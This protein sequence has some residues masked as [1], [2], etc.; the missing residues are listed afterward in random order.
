[1]NANAVE[2][3][4]A[5]EWNDATVR[6]SRFGEGLPV[7]LCHGTPW[8]SYVWRSTIEA[9]TPDCAVY[10]WDMVGYGQSDKPNSD[11]S[12]GTQG[13]LL[14]ALV[15]HWNLDTPDVIAH[16]YGGTVS[17]RAHLLHGMKVR[18]LALVDV[19]ALTP[20]GSP[21]FRL[22]AEHPDVFTALPPNLHEA[23]VREYI[24]G[25]SGPG[26]QPAVL[27]ELVDPWLYDGQP[28]FY[29]QIAQAD[30]RFTAEAETHYGT[31]TA[32][33]LIVWGTADEWIP[34]D[35]A[36]RLAHVIPD[37]TVE[38]IDGAGHLVQE[39]NPA[40]LNLI[41]SRWIRSNRP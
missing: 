32:P 40:E 22:V 24:S 31:I 41:L 16:D 6:W 8:S 17:L 26:L 11:V 7:V 4:E 23:L 33:T 13:K 2:L 1:M 36:H 20:W 14:A 12:L 15:K 30:E 37:S 27:D 38:L 3:T 34:V 25:A 10:V 28:A 21:F 9:L 29:R 35:R 18:S 19:V 39:D 5:F